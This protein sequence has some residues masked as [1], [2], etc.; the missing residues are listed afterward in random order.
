M[1]QKK[2]FFNLSNIFL[3]IYRNFWKCPS[4]SG[5]QNHSFR[6]RERMQIAHW[7]VLSSVPCLMKT[8]LL[9]SVKMH[10]HFLEWVWN[11]GNWYTSFPCGPSG[12][13]LWCDCSSGI[14]LLVQEAAA[15]LMI[16]LKFPPLG[17]CGPNRNKQQQ[18]KT[19]TLCKNKHGYSMEKSLTW[20][21]LTLCS[22]NLSCY[23][24]KD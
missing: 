24:N 17:Q 9:V 7:T 22:S 10:H 2:I 1:P 11:T 5:L 18:L 8:I 23:L 14:G 20:R 4:F 12:S 19:P 3:S 21:R 16:I 13:Y 15:L 6:E